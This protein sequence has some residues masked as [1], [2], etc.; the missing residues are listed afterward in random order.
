[1]PH[2]HEPIIAGCV[3]LCVY[4]ILTGYDG[5]DA[6]LLGVGVPLPE[7]ASVGFGLVR[8][9]SLPLLLQAVLVPQVI[10]HV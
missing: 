8:T 10:L 2:T 9:Q 6:V 3:L 1:M 4:S 7:A 5:A